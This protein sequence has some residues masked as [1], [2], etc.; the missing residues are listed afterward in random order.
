MM[1]DKIRLTRR[2]AALAENVAKD[3]MPMRARKKNRNLKEG[4]LLLFSN[5]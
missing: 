2:T 1:D 5:S 3:K 4:M